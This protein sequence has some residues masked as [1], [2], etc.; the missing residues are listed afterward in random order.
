MSITGL[1]IVLI[2]SFALNRDVAGI[3][4]MEPSVYLLVSFVLVLATMPA[5]WLAARIASK[6]DPIVA[7]TL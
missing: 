5:C 7:P 6:V 1:V 4:R 3:G 2:G